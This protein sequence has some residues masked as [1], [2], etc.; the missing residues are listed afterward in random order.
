MG[1]STDGL[2]WYGYAWTKEGEPPWATFD[3]D[4][5][6]TD[7]GE[8]DDDDSEARFVRL[9]GFDGKRGDPDYY[10]RRRA[11]LATATCEVIHHCSGDCTMYGVGIAESSK[12]AWRGSPQEDP[13]T[14]VRPDWD[15]KL[16]AYCKLM[17]IDTGDQKPRWWLASN[18]G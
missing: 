10:E 2:L 13:F 15:E 17:G 3:E 11:L 5:E 14:E 12:R 6:R 16:T 8:D 18:W 7:D 9:S 4:Y 1:Q